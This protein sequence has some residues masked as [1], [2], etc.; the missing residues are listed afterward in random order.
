MTPAPEPDGQRRFTLLVNPAAGRGRARRACDI[1]VRE[2]RRNGAHVDVRSASTLRQMRRWSD[3]AV[4]SAQASAD[5][6]EWHAVVAVGGDGSV[7]TV[8]QSVADT[9]VPFGAV[10]AGSG[11]D[12][13]RAW[14]L[15]RAR[16][17]AAAR[18]LL[19]GDPTPMDLGRCR[20][21]R[22]STRFFGT[23]VA[24]G[25]DARVSERALR[26]GRVPPTVRYLAAVAAEL[27]SLRPLHYRLVLDGV[28]WETD[29][30]LVA[31]ANSRSYGGG[32]AVCP[33]ADPAD[34][35]LDVL[36]LRPLSTAQFVR[37][38]PRVYRGTHLSHPA[39]SVVRAREVRV[40]ANDVVAFVDGERVG[41]LPQ[42]V[43]VQ[44]GGLRVV[45]AQVVAR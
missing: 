41:P 15:P 39:V 6:Q 42:T 40:E 14:G 29:A 24:A 19:T 17:H 33:D 8:L 11:D 23:V 7:H 31:L 28:S 37:V 10:A 13:A 44:P 9:G 16:P 2:L 30:M 34:G 12:A 45:G 36:V 43:A 18:A 35:L 32:M 25:F 21:E 26:L 3:E 20:D 1:V 38:F 27:R 22:G 4:A 5:Q